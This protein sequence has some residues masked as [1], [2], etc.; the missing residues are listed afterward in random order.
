MKLMIA[1]EFASTGAVEISLFQR[2]SLGNGT[3]P[4]RTRTLSSRHLAAGAG[5]ATTAAAPSSTTSAATATSTTGA[6][7]PAGS[8][9]AARA[10]RSAVTAT[11]TEHHQQ[12][13]QSQQDEQSTSDGYHR[14][15]L[16]TFSA[17]R[18]MA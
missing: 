14:C 10:G 3:N 4:C 17:V 13:K 18:Q 11:A 6:S 8:A 12:T 1:E 5:R 7:A 2:L 15:H 16:R 9:T